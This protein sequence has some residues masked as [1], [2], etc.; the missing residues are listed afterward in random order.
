MFSNSNSSSHV[1]FIP[2]IALCLISSGCGETK[3]EVITRAELTPIAP[4]DLCKRIT[5]ALKQTQNGRQL[6]T[7]QQGAW[8]IVH[9]ILAFGE[10]FTVRNR[11][12]TVSALDYL[13]QGGPLQGW[14]LQHG[15]HGVVAVVE[16]GSTL[17]QGHRNQWLG[18]LSQCGTDGV[19]LETSLI[20]GEQ[21]ANVGDLLR[22]AQADIRSGQEAPWT[23][24]AFATYLPGDK[25]WKASD[26]EEWD[27]S[28]IIEM[29]LDTDL[30]SSACGGSHSLYGLAIAVNKYRS[31]HSESNDVLP[32]PWG[33]AQEIITNSIDLS[34][35]FQQADGSFSTHY[36]ERPASSAD[37]FAKLS[38]SGHVFE[39][40]A[41][42]LPADRLDEPWVLRAAERLVKTLEQTADIDI[43]CGALY[44]AAHGLLL[45]RN[46]LR[47]MP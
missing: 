10:Q 28:R 19:P 14:K 2:C 16:E 35:R 1:L 4:A 17:G 31:Q 11:T 8:Q 47:L 24:M 37:V 26:G 13:L 25:T 44:H 5:K 12:E 7:E 39:F 6:T 15:E 45:Y 29:E 46:R 22:Q 43:E 21:S 41:I 36:F 27:I 32:A 38:S 30:H 42:A 20:V 33:T 3:E 34:R 18:Y 9:G 40:L 23:L